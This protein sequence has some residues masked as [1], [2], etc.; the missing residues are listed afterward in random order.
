VWRA[1]AADGSTYWAKQNCP[2]QAFETRLL[3]VLDAIAPDRVVPVVAADPERGLHLVPD[4]GRVFAETVGGDDLDAWCRIA[5]EAM[6]LQRNLVGHAADLVGA[7][8]S[9]MRPAEAAA[10]VRARV[11]SLEALPEGDPRR[12]APEVADGLRRR[13]PDVAA[14][15]A[16]LDELA[17][18]ENLVHNDLHANNVFATPAG[19]RFFDFGDSVLAHPLSASSSPSTCCSTAWR[20]RR[21]TRGCGGSRTPG[22]RSGA[23]SCRWRS[24]A[25]HYQRRCTSGGCCAPSR[26]CA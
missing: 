6:Q 22:S 9:V 5:T 17:L 25:P 8:V 14:W 4:Q 10:Y 24:C 18:A 1:F 7:G 21:T 20:R 12:M 15:A 2:H 23:T 11:A 16:D 19:M 26:G 3:V 13:L